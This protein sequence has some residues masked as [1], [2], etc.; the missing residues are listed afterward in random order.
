VAA[1]RTVKVG[2]T[3][4]GNRAKSLLYS[5]ETLRNGSLLINFVRIFYI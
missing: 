5:G 2:H 1:P 4:V 3:E